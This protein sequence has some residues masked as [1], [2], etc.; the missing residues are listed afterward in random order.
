MQTSFGIGEGLATLLVA[1][2]AIGYMW[3]WRRLRRAMPK[4]ATRP[5][6]IAFV[7][8]LCALVLA[9]VWPLPD[10]SNYLLAMR[11][12]Q[13]ALICMVAAPLLWVATPVH[14]LRWGV[15]GWARGA[16]ANLNLQ[17][18]A[19]RLM[20]AITQPLFTWF[21]YVSTFLVW[22]DPSFAQY[23]LGERWT[24]T[25]APWLLLIAAILF[26]WPV[27]DAGPRFHRHSPTWL[28]IV[29]LLS[30]E[31]ANMIA[32]VSIAFTAE[33]LYLYYPAVRAQ[34]DPNALPISQATDQIAGGAIV[35][36][37]GSF[38]YISAIVSVL[39]RLFRK[40]GSGTPQPLPDWDADDK[41]IAP[42]LEERVRQNQ[43]RK[44]DLS[45][46]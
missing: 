25:A 7:V 35:W 26:W 32:G 1:G 8:A 34:L 41:F 19:T 37:F 33:P 9:L 14:A 28:L 15:R 39:Y 27:V 46:H 3:G 45:H 22:H 16:F 31:I 18:W 13:K 4:L 2:L 5:R 21:F 23:L 42:G 38:V 40:E 20:R 12:L 43:L 11:S 36:V 30:V 17:G 10:W 29:Y 24:H 6:L 44:A